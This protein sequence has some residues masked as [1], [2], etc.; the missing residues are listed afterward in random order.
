MEEPTKEQKPNIA[1]PQQEDR[2]K[3]WF[4]NMLAFRAGCIANAHMAPPRL[5]L[6]DKDVKET[7]DK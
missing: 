3:I 2:L 5:I 7:K 4:E 1:E 6:E